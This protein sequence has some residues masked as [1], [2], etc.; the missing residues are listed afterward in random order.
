[1]T[2]LVQ[3]KRYA[4]IAE[5]L[6]ITYKTVVNITSRLRLKLGVSSL[7]ELIR[8]AVELLSERRP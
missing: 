4:L 6:G 3:G 8:K 7:P 1:L 2:L 5:E